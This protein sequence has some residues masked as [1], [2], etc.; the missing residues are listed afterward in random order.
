MHSSLHDDAGRFLLIRGQNRAQGVL[1]KFLVGRIV[2]LEDDYEDRDPKLLK[3]DVHWYYPENPRDLR[4][5]KWLPVVDKGK[6]HLQNI[7]FKAVWF[8]FTG[9]R[10]ITQC[11]PDDAISF[12]CE[13]K[14]L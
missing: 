7:F 8:Q 9:F 2:E 13:E 12:L 1:R 6:P 5:S 10:V 11:L 14:L 3:L 4:T